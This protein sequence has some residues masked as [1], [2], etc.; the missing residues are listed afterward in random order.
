[1]SVKKKTTVKKPAKV[2]TVGEVVPAGTTAYKAVRGGVRDDDWYI[3]K[4]TTAADGV[5]LRWNT[6]FPVKFK[7]PSVIVNQAWLVTGGACREC[8]YYTKKGTINTWKGCFVADYGRYNATSRFRYTLGKLA[9]VKDY[10]NDSSCGK[11]IHL[12]PTR[13]AAIDYTE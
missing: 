7:V 4:C 5:T 11:G 1:M 9:I 3:L 12:F 2:W 13:A 8:S 10:V 6:K